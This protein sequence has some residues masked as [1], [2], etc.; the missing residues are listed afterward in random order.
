M[1]NLF[2][3]YG[4]PSPTPHMQNI[5]RSKM[6]NMSDDDLFHNAIT[7]MVHPIMVDLANDVRESLFQSYIKGDDVMYGEYMK[8]PITKA[9]LFTTSLV[10]QTDL[11]KEKE[12]SYLYVAKDRMKTDGSVLPS[13]S[14]YLIC[15][16]IRKEKMDLSNIENFLTEE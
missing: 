1:K 16:Y 10:L 6:M 8:E 13:L 3:Q 14:V 4:L 11:M 5:I 12:K 2:N 7:S 9:E 15:K